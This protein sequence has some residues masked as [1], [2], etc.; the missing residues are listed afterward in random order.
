M[1]L[2]NLSKEAVEE[3]KANPVTVALQ[4]LL[5]WQIQ[6][7]KQALLQAYWRGDEASAGQRQGVAML[8]EYHADLFDSTAEDVNAIMEMRDEQQRN[9]AA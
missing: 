9:T 2:R 1:T 3:W 4:S 7:R 5:G 6:R 8:E